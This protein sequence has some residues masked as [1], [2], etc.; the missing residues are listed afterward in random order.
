[1]LLRS[2]LGNAGIAGRYML[3]PY[4]ASYICYIFVCSARFSTC[5]LLQIPTCSLAVRLFLINGGPVTISH[6]GSPATLSYCSDMGEVE[7]VCV[8]VCISTATGILESSSELIS[9]VR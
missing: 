3:R 2:R 8:C 7:R 6:K 5:E 1:M 4:C 9:N